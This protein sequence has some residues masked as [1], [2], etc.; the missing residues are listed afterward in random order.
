MIKL[1]GLM[2]I[3]GREVYC[4]NLEVSFEEELDLPFDYLTDDEEDYYDCDCEDCDCCDEDEDECEDLNPL[5][6]LIEEYAEILSEECVC[7]DCIKGILEN[8]VYDLIN[9]E[10]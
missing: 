10:E 1:N 2:F 4:D 8:F 9:E 6:K 5:E 3:D 7:V